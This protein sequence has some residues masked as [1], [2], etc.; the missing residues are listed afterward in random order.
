MLMP[1]LSETEAAVRAHER[2]L[3]AEPANA[4]FVAYRGGRAAGIATFRP[5][6]TNHPGLLQPTVHLQHGFTIETERGS[7]VGIALLSHGLVWAQEQ[8]Y[9]RCTVNWVAANP[10]GARF[11]Q[12]QG[13]VPIA[14]RLYGRIDPRILFG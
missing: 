3:L 13:F 1:F 11:W 6:A 12:R 5:W 4:R 7:G 2:E 10:L 14:A 8:G 9:E